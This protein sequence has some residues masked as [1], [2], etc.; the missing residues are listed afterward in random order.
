MPTFSVTFERYFPPE[1]GEE[2]CDADER[3]FVIE[4]V[5]L[6]DAIEEA[7]GVYASYE[8]SDSRR[9][10]ARWYTNYQYSEGTREWL[11]TGISE[12]RSFHIPETVTIASR[13]RIARLLG[14]K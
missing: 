12:V 7:G 9:G 2:V 5:S 11:E 8:A 10:H 13:L 4:G 1:E 3:G 14:I 6:R